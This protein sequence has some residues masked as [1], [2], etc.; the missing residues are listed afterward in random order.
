[1]KSPTPDGTL[2]ALTALNISIITRLRD[3]LDPQAAG[4]LE[5][6]LYDETIRF[7]IRIVDGSTCVV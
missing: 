6:R 7:N 4:R 3:R 5:I 2:Q 1:V